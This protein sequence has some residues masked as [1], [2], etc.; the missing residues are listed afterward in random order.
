MFGVRTAN[1]QRKERKQK[2]DE[3]EEE[4][5]QRYQ[6]NEIHYYTREPEIK[7]REACPDFLV[8]EKDGTIA[9]I[10]CLTWKAS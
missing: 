3:F 6:N 1:K 2:Q 10:T 7:P 8:C 9:H 4:L 5:V